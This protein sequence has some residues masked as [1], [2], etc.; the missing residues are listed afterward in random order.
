M[1]RCP[2]FNWVD[3]ALLQHHGRNSSNGNH[4]FRGRRLTVVFDLRGIPG[5]ILRNGSRRRWKY[6]SLEFDN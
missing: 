1:A 4:E 2:V 5:S 6:G 3:E